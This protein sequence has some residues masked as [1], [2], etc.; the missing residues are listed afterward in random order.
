MNKSFSGSGHFGLQGMHERASQ[1]SA[2]LHVESYPG[3][4]TKVLLEVP[5]TIERGLKDNV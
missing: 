2:R 5:I 1:I 3:R 4:G